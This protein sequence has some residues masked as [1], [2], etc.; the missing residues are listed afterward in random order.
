MHNLL[1]GVLGLGAVLAVGAV[2]TCVVL[3]SRKRRQRVWFQEEQRRQARHKRLLSSLETLDL[4]MTRLTAAAVQGGEQFVLERTARL[5]RVTAAVDRSGDDELRRLI[6]AVV[7]GCDAL[8]TVRREGEERDRLVRRLG[9]A[10]REVYRR[11]E[12]LLGQAFD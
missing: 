6:E 11:M 2:V 3:V 9:D 4:A 10:Q 1:D 7:A 8:S 5:A 12:V